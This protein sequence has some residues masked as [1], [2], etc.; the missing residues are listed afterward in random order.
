MA[1]C[2]TFCNGTTLWT[3]SWALDCLA[4]VLCCAYVA[5][6]LNEALL[7]C[8]RIAFHGVTCKFYLVP[9]ISRL[10]PH[11]HH[12]HHHK[13]SCFQKKILNVGTSLSL[14]VSCVPVRTRRWNKKKRTWAFRRRHTWEECCCV[15]FEHWASRTKTVPVSTTIAIYAYWPWCKSDGDDVFSWRGCDE[16]SPIKRDWKSRKWE[17]FWRGALHALEC[18]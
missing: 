12:T 4:E 13:D 6:Y 8:T 5:T 10:P 15:P 16:R 11:S 7:S 14:S 3:T 2:T 9:K 18:I 17:F 1:H